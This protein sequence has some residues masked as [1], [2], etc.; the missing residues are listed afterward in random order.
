[1][2]ITEV[3]TVY[4]MN[5]TERLVTQYVKTK[6]DIGNSTLDVV[7]MKYSVVLYAENGTEDNYTN[8]GRVVDLQA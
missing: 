7:K 4:G 1:M 2:K 8:R 6:Y 5:N 3:S